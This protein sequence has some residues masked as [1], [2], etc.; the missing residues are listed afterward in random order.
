MS[1]NGMNGGLSVE[2]EMVW[3]VECYGKLNAMDS[4]IV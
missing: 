4:R 1:R 3:T 2:S